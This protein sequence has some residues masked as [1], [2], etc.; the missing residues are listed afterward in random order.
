MSKTVFLVAGGT[1]GHVFP[2]LAL[3]EELRRRNVQ[4][5]CITDKRAEKYYHQTQIVPHLVESSAWASD[6]FGKAKAASKIMYG[7]IQSFELYREHRPSCVVGFGG[8]PTF[9]TLK[10][11]QL[12]K[13]PT[14]LHEQNAVFGRANRQLASHAA[15]IATS[16]QDTKSLPGGTQSI[17]VYT[18][19]PV[20]ENFVGTQREFR[21]PEDGGVF[22][23]FIFGGSQGS[24]M[25][26]KILPQA[27]ELLPADLRARVNIIQQAR[28]EDVDQLTAVY[29]KIGVKARIQPFFTNILQLYNK[30]HLVISRAGASTISELTALGL[31]SIIVPLAISLD[32][33][34]AQ[35]ARHLVTHQAGIMIEEKDFTSAT[36]AAKLTE[37]LSHP[38]QLG[39]MAQAAKNLGKPAASSHLADLVM[40]YL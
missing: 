11:G 4:V 16:F 6:W 33:D 24:M 30:A 29:K 19:N 14:I 21:L 13:I 10:A 3:A 2:A 5:E 26:S 7:M 20:R 18:G 9:P 36:L 17:A 22:N 12:L 25:F 1:G 31:P 34:Q 40:K 32:G 23:L 28:H 37:L 38:A 8:Y 15:A 27:L 35:N 39:A